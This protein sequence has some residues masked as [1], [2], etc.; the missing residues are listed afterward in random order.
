MKI[1]FLIYFLLPSLIQ[2]ATNVA[3]VKLLRGQVEV[4]VGGKPKALKL[5]DWVQE[6]VVVRTQDKSFVK[7]VFIDKSQMNIGPSSELKIEKFG[8]KEAGVIDVVKGK[9]RSQVTKDYLQMQNEDQSKLFI[10]SKNAVMGV[11]GTDFLIT[12]N[13]QNTALVLFEGEV[14]FNHLSETGKIP[15]AKLEDIVDRGVRVKPGEFSVV[16]R[17]RPQPTVPA[18]LNVKQRE[19]L[20]SNQDFQTGRTPS[21]AGNETVKSVVP[22]GLSGQSVSNESDTLKNELTQVSNVEVVSSSSSEN[23]AGTVSGDVV[24]P[25]NGSF[26]HLESGVVIP[27]PAD[28]VFDKNTNSFVASGA[29]GTVGADGNFVPPANMEITND[30]KVLLTVELPQ[31]QTKVVELPKPAPVVA[32]NSVSLTQV[33][34]TVTQNPNLITSSGKVELNQPAPVNTLPPTSIAP[35][36]TGGIDL[37]TNVIQKVSGQLNINVIK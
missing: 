2:A 25:A 22:E 23:A 10:K 35:P 5:D 31:G 16:E 8:G 36:P 34:Q 21:Q 4:V 14:V 29:N 30:G 15:N 9:V 12:T 19:V 32:T 1:I 24:K 33:G 3:V 13:G 27:P 28:S 6:G 17:D 37:N 7:L 18:V 11:R 26:V 20:E